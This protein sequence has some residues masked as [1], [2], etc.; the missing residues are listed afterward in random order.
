MLPSNV[1]DWTPVHVITALLFV[2]GVVE[3]AR[4]VTDLLDW[5]YTTVRRRWFNAR[6][7]K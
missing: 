3:A 2:I 5:S 7:L 4:L 6:G 1:L